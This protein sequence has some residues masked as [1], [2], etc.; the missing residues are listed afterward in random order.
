MTDTVSLASVLVLL[1]AS[2]AA[3]ALCRVLKLPALVGYLITGLAL[4]PHAL[5]V[6]S[7]VQETQQLA[8]FGVVFLMFSIGLEFS[9]GKL[10]AMRRVVFAL[11]GAQV[12]ATLALALVASAARALGWRA[13]IALGAIAAMS[14]TAIVSRLLAERGEL[15]SPHG[16]QVIGV[17]LFQDLAVVLL[18]VLVPALAQSAGGLG[19][20]VGVALGKAVVALGLVVLLGP[21]LMRAWLG[22]V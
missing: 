12:A 20:A 8:E 3:V 17:L 1:A 16:R 22:L 2:V 9:L 5:G 7:N 4:G 15:D 10:Y 13:G 11:G 19:I 14:S 21:R 6:A 18:I